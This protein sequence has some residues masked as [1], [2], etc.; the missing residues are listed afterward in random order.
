MNSGASNTEWIFKTT[1]AGICCIDAN[2]NIRCNNNAM[3]EMFNFSPEQLRNSKC[4]QVVDCPYAHTSDCL[5]NQ[6]MY[7]KK[8]ADRIII[9]ENKGNAPHISWLPQPRFT[10]RMAISKGN[11]GTGYHEPGYQC[12]RRNERWRQHHHNNQKDN[13]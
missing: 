7:S 2:F 4:Y 6:V 5:L 8:S 12:L 9:R 1:A 11:F 10:N 3:E 13:H